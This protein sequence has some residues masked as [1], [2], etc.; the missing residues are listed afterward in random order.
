MQ[1]EMGDS[2]MDYAAAPFPVDPSVQDAANPHGSIECDV[3]VVPRNVRHPEGSLAFVSFLQ[4]PEN[5][6]RLA[7]GHG[8]PS[9]LVKPSSAFL[10]EHPNRSIEVHQ[11][12]M[13][14]KNAFAEPFT[15]V[16]PEFSNSLGAGMS[17]IDV[18][19]ATPSEAFA[20]VQEEVQAQLIRAAARRALRESRL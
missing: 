20:Q 1:E 14:S 10:A 13:V 19:Q 2:M 7:S 6:E 4:Q 9:P 17:Q 18:L 3:L 16:W 8:K 5:L 12:I 15:E 11:N